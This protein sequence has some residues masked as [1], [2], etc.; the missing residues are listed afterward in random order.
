MIIPDCVQHEFSLFNSSLE[1]PKSYSKWYVNV[2]F[3][4]W[5]WIFSKWKN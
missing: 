5:E 3:N 1:K 2:L 4:Q